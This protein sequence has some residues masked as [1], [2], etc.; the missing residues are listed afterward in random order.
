MYKTMCTPDRP[1]ARATLIAVRSRAED[2]KMA[3]DRAL[4][5]F[6]VDLHQVI[7]PI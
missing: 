7:G 4:T 1:E 5:C 2:V 6:S 3:M